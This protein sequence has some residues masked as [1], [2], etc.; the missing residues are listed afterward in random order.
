MK[1]VSVFLVRLRLTYV[2]NKHT[3][4]DMAEWLSPEPMENDSYSEQAIFVKPNPK[5]IS[6]SISGCFL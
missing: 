3:P 5:L 2:P 6:I 1:Y 4:P